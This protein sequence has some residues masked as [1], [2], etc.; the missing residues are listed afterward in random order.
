MDEKV[1]AAMEIRS[2]I[3]K[4]QIEIVEDL[5]G[6]DKDLLKIMTV[7][8]TPL[9]VAASHGQL[10]IAKLLIRLGADVNRKGGVSG[11]S[12]LN[13]AAS[14]GHIDL[15]HLLLSS[16]AELDVSE[17]ERNPLFSAIYG[18]HLEIAK[19]LVEHGIDIHAQYNGD[20]M[21]NMDAFAFAIE[22]GQK[23]IADLLK[24]CG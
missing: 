19:L 22:R 20:S 24:S 17:P 8:G 3:K 14:A 12:A 4:G 16:G 9:H 21:K 13:Q 5:I 11:G 15:V 7:F 1:A 18:G 10:E 6:S 23:E 2:A